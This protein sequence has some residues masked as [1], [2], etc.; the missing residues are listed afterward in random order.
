MF[1][2]VAFIHVIICIFL[3]L[4]ILMQSAKGH[5]LAGAF[6]SF[7]GGVAQNLFGAQ[8]GDVLTKATTVV[9]ALFVATSLWLAVLSANK[10]TSLMS[11]TKKEAAQ[12]A[13]S[14]SSKPQASD[15]SKT[16]VPAQTG[17]DSQQSAKQPVAESSSASPAATAE[18]ASESAK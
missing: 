17:T 10:G 16:A 11:K 13:S 15:Q 8:A 2:V 18:K 6:G 1:T 12:K 7:G 3:V 9:A 5:G 4:V 14:Q